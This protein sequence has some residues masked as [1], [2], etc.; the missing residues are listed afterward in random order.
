MKRSLLAIALAA[1]LAACGSAHKDDKTKG[2]SASKFYTEARAELADGNYDKAAQLFE[3]LESRYPFGRYAQQAQLE[4]I[5]IY[6]KKGEIEQTLAAADRFGRLHPNHPNVDYAYY[7]KGLANFIDDR[8]LFRLVSSQDPTERDPKAAR[9]SFEAFKLLVARYPESKYAAD[10]AARMTYLIN[11]LASGEVHVA[12][13]YFKRGAYVAVVN[14]AQY[15]LQNYPQ[16]PAN[17]EAL[18]LLVRAYN[19]M[20]LPDLRDDALRVLEKNFPGS[21]Y[22]KG[23]EKDPAWWMFWKLI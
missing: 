14:R 8:S 20:G 16:A 6:Y 21:A 12:R 19:E 1:P 3:K 10:A 18:A 5:Y 11:A 17:E 13:Y 7:L 15:A 22:L 2:W 23:R 9:Q 4:I